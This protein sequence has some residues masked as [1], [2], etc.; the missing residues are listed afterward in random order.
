[1]AEAQNQTPARSE[2]TGA[3]APRP[4]GEE[5]RHPLMAFRDEMDRLFDDFFSGFSLSPFRRRRLEADPWRRFQGVFE[6]TFPVVDVTETESEYRVKAELPGMEEK[7]I[8][9]ALTGGVLMIKGEK[10]QEQEEK[11][12]NYFV[13]ERRYGTFQRSFRL[14]EDVDPEKIEASMKSGVLTLTLPK[15]P[16]AQAKAKKIEVKTS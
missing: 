7:D 11:K 9:I 14:P 13:S 6:A 1:M 16:E 2:P 3:P 15:R 4:S 10:R 8:D 5:T 12:E